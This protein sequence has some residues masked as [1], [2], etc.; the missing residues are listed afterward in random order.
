MFDGKTKA[1]TFSYD[2]AVTQDHLLI[3]RLCPSAEHLYFSAQLCYS[4][5]HKE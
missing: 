1:L 3:A 4:S 2:D 5:L